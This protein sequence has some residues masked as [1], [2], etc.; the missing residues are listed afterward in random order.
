VRV[1]DHLVLSTA[2][3]AAASPW[4]GRRAIGLWAGG[5]L[6]DA[7]HYLWFCLRHRRL[8]PAAAVRLFNEAHAPQHA[9]TRVLHTRGALLAAFALSLGRAGPLAVAAGMG[10]H[11]ALDAQHEARM[12][13]ARARALERD[14]RACRGCGARGNRVGTHLA[15]QPRL[16]PSYGPENLVSL[17]AACHERAHAEPGAAAAWK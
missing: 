16:L 1:R 7:D 5:V 2:G 6:I 4:L 17:C 10:L 14:G 12:N 11:V 3:A 13:R 8:S 9:G 15:R